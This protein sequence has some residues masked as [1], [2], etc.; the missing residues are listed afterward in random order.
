MKNIP[1]DRIHLIQKAE[2]NEAGDYLLYWM[3]LSFRTHWNYA[4]EYAVG[5]AEQ[6]DSQVV[7]LVNLELTQKQFTE[8]HI[9]FVLE[10]LQEVEESLAERQ[11]KFVFRKEKLAE[12][13]KDLEKNAIGIVTDFPYLEEEVERLQACQNATVLPLT[14]VEGNV[15]VP[16]ESAS[17][18]Q[19]YAAR[20]IRS[21]LME[22]YQHYLTKPRSS[23]VPKASQ[24]LSIR[25]DSL[26]NVDELVGDFR[27]SEHTKPIESDYQGGWSEAKKR[28]DYFLNNEL[29]A[30]DESRQSPTDRSVS[31]LSMYLSRGMI[32]PA[33]IL[34]RLDNKT[35]SE[36]T[37]SYLEELL[38]RR[39]LTH[40]FVHFA[41]DYQSLSALPE[42]A[43]ETLEN[44]KNDDREH[45]YT[46]SEFEAADTHDEAWNESMQ[47]MKT[48]GYLHNHMR[49]YWGKQILAWSESPEAAH[50]TLL[51]LNNKYFLDGND[52]NSYANVLWIFGLH[53]RAWKE[54]E[55]FGKVR[56]M[57]RNGLDRKI[58][59]ERFVNE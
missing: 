40:N 2:A 11:I 42:W 30:Y 52:P 41:D 1:D 43:Q 34:S 27:Y 51:Y 19:E 47:R 22:Q 36:N 15:V 48:T 38:V 4:L 44:H 35:T 9:R 49:M 58:D 10:G 5:L 13:I 46:R 55:V 14:A 37:K 23:E 28:L 7:V 16:V 57:N 17:D 53:D 25:S 33:Y 59:V 45:T 56:T 12:S 50:E 31:E 3:S 32:A 21:K 18:K 26:K 29:A 20:T 54:T 24:N 8:R 6:H 39:E